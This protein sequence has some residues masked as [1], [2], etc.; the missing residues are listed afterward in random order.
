RAALRVTHRDLVGLDYEILDRDVHV[1]KRPP[2]ELARSHVRVASD[3]RL[4]LGAVIRGIAISERRLAHG[5]VVT[6]EPV[7]DVVTQERAELVRHPEIPSGSGRRRG[8]LL[9]PQALLLTGC[10]PASDVDRELGGRD[11]S[12]GSESPA[13]AVAAA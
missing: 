10:D 9:S 12:V 4:S 5:P 2:E 6:I 3:V 13:A 11:R 8:G 1:G 7:F